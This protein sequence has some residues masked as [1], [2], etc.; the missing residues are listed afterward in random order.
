MATFDDTLPPDSKYLGNLNG[1][2]LETL[3]RSYRERDQV[4]HNLI[5]GFDWDKPQPS[6]KKMGPA[7]R[8]FKD[9][10]D[11]IGLPALDGL[12]DVYRE[13]YVL[14]PGFW[15]CIK[16]VRRIFRNIKGF[17]FNSSDRSTMERLMRSA[18][19][20]CA[21]FPLF[22][23]DHQKDDLD[24]AG[25]CPSQ[26]YRRIVNTRGPGAHVCIVEAGHEDSAGGPHGVHIDPHQIA[27]SRIDGTHCFYQYLL[28]HFS[29]VGPH[30]IADTL[31]K[32]RIIPA[33]VRIVS[34]AGATNQGA[35][36]WAL[37]ASRLASMDTEQIKRRLEVE[38]PGLISLIHI[39]PFG[40][41]AEATIDRIVSRFLQ[42]MGMLMSGGLNPF[43]C[44]R[45]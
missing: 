15:A 24:P 2:V 11:V 6:G 33:L 12:N 16:S 10:L 4:N 20:F 18:N 28:D 43:P 27:A 1:E 34:V 38:I 14:V 17:T 39:Q 5:D 35:T 3:R 44:G 30:L 19:S 26:C 21:D 41:S 40:L 9:V 45:I 13:L 31:F 29:D 25:P 32:D 22:Q 8:S 7:D 37:A 42:V 23:V 36:P